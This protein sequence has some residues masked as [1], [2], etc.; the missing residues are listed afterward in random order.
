MYNIPNKIYLQT[1]GGLGDIVRCYLKDEPY[2]G[3][4]EWIKKQKPSTDIMVVSTSHNPNTKDF[5]KYNPFV[6]RMEELGW[7]VDGRP[8]AREAARGYTSI[9]QI[10]PG[11]KPRYQKPEI[12]LG[13]EDLET[14]NRIKAAGKYVFM[15]PFAYR[16]IL[17]LE[18][19]VHAIDRIID[20]SDLNV[21][22][23]GATHERVARPNAVYPGD[24]GGKLLVTEELNYERPRLF[25]LTNKSNV[26]VAMRL[27]QES[28][29][30]MGH[31]SCYNIVA[32]IEGIKSFVFSPPGERQL[33]TTLR[34][35]AW[36][37]IDNLPWC[38]NIY[39]DEWSSSRDAVDKAVEFILS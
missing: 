37:L 38:K 9:E 33:L 1:G 11:M 15:H 39:S 30:F 36:P 35:H 17:P 28:Y 19:F 25:N 27:C 20:E 14:Y 18:D 7:V 24:P 31:C 23:V 29:R 12:Y 13:P 5:F 34:S 21:V 16:S 6:D 8:L 4:L 2:W 26:R 32:W 3:V 22:V 10:Y